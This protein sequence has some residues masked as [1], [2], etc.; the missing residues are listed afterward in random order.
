MKIVKL[1]TIVLATTVCCIG[2]SLSAEATSFCDELE[3]ATV[4]AEDGTYLGKMESPYSTDSMFN[5]YGTYGSRYSQDSI[6]NEYGEYG[7]KYS[8]NS[9]FNRYSSTPPTI[10]TKT[11]KT[12]KLTIN[13]HL[14]YTVNPYV[15]RSCFE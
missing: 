13:K 6:W 5:E 11:K 10:Y 2:K 7:G 8:V 15:A 9:P 3:G 14:P 12:S 1:L 4:I